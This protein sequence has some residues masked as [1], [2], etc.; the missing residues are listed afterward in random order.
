MIYTT[1]AIINIFYGMIDSNSESLS[2]FK[3]K[4]W[5]SGDEIFK[6]AEYTK[7]LEEQIKRH[8]TEIRVLRSL[9][10]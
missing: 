6:K 7:E 2:S 1:K 5:Y 3:N 4:L 8:K 10:K 9:I